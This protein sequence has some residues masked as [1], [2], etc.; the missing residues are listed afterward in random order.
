MAALGDLELALG[1]PAEAVDRLSDMSAALKRLGIADVDLSPAPELT[2]ALVQ[3]GRGEEAVDVCTSY[4]RRAA[5][6]G[7]P[8]ALARAARAEGLV[9]D[10]EAFAD[11]FEQALRWHEATPDTFERARTELAYGERL[12][13]ARRRGDARSHLRAAFSAFHGLGRGAV[14]RTCTTRARGDRRDDTQARPE[15]PRPAHA[16][17]AAGRA[18][19]RL[20]PDHPG[21]S[22]QALSQPQDGR[23]PPAQR[24]SQARHRL[25]DRACRGVRPYRSQMTSQRLLHIGV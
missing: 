23:V 18:R 6:K 14:G 7:Q 8:W 24:L 5:A 15:H 12:R 4:R 1:R 13:R 10:E 17:R 9:A 19:S 11:W 22:R 20:G 25:A 3:C 21:G 2:E 16:A